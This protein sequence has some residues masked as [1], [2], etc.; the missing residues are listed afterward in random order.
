M[1]PGGQPGG[2]QV[3]PHL[4]LVVVP[5]ELDQVGRPWGEIG[6]HFFL[7][8]WRLGLEQVVDE[9]V[10]GEV[11]KEMVGVVNF[12]QGNILRCCLSVG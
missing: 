3:E 5:Q 9:V 8:K 1:G 11:G 4:F 7:L 6:P 10:D 2:N 12:N